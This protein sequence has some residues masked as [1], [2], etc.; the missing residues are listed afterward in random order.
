MK[1]L[2]FII[3]VCLAAKALV[4]AEPPASPR[5]GRGAG[6]EAFIQRLQQRRTPPEIIAMDVHDRILERAR[7]QRQAEQE[8]HQAIPRTAGLG[9]GAFEE[10]VETVQKIALKKPDTQQ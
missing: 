6:K 1:K 7:A 4:G 2:L 10:Y 9:Y 3:G 8:A 5:Q